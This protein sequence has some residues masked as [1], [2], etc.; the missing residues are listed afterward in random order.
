[1]RLTESFTSVSWN[2]IE[3]KKILPQKYENVFF[4]STR[5]ICTCRKLLNQQRGFWK[6]RFSLKKKAFNSDDYILIVS[7]R[8]GA[9]L[10]SPH[11]VVLFVYKL[12]CISENV[13]KCSYCIPP[14]WRIIKIGEASQAPVG[15]SQAHKIPYIDNMP[16]DGA[17]VGLGEEDN[18]LLLEIIHWK[19]G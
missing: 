12:N 6:Y 19:S 14:S 11:Y 5:Y 8:G 7:S 13:Q 10:Y 16:Q 2:E 3:D 17:G 15:A 18:N 4:F 1:M 9:F